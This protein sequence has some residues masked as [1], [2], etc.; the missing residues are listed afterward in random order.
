MLISLLHK[1]ALAAGIVL[2]I[3]TS[4]C[5]ATPPLQGPPPLERTA[6]TAASTSTMTRQLDDP[7]ANPLA[8]PLDAHAEDPI[9]FFTVQHAVDV[10]SSRCM[11]RSG[12]FTVE[13]ANYAHLAESFVEAD[14]RHYGITDR[15]VAAHYGYMPK[16][17]S[18][19]RSTSQPGPTPRRIP[20]CSRPNRTGRTA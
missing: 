19:S 6:T 1:T 18:G 5:A 17:T 4:G 3:A 9:V 10:L 7:L 13:P 16:P 20:R 15:A 14:S 12:R 8:D 11:E 2:L